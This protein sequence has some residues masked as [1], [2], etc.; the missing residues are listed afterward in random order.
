MLK[1]S[2]ILLGNLCSMPSVP[3]VTVFIPAYNRQ[4]YIGL[5]I[6]SILEQDFTDLEVLVV[7]DGST[8]QTPELV[9]SYDDARV[10]LERSP[11]NAG[12]PAARNRGLACARGEYIA[13]LDSDDFSYPE[14]LSRQ[15]AFLDANSSIAQVGS[16]CSLMDDAA[17]LLPR[18]RRQPTRCT[19]VDVH[20]LFHC[21][22]INRTIMARTA[23]LKEFGYDE[24][25]PRCQ[26]YDL[27]ARLSEHHA[28][29][30]LPRI[31]V[32][33]REHEGRFTRAT[34]DVGRDRKMAIQASLLD[35]LGMEFGDDDLALH[36]G[37]SQRPDAERP[38]AAEHLAWAEHWLTAIVAANGRRQRYD[39]GA[40]SRAVA[41]IWASTCWFDRRASGRHWLRRV[42]GSRLSADLPRAI[43][44]RWLLAAA[45][46]TNRKALSVPGAA[47]PGRQQRS[48]RN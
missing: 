10:R 38:P 36:Y 27:H 11:E 48:I 28:M 44:S 20:L 23:I 16:W 8:D 35:T 39:P 37:L 43:L 29:A 47:A 30:N 42:T 7:D 22:L 15:V 17:N 2:A 3:R 1:N 34:R 12:I 9:E 31:L 5:A 14:R 33:G 45:L 19:D 25:F 4:D 40:L 6:D 24:R 32:C 13:L 41:L 26:D 21:S 46:P 18:I